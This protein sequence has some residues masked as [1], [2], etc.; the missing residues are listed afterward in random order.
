MISELALL[1]L[2]VKPL[3]LGQVGLADRYEILLE[4]FPH[5]SIR[6]IDRAVIRRAAQLRGRY[7]L[8][9]PDAIH[10]ATAVESGATLFV[11]NDKGLGPVKGIECVVLDDFV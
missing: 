2:L 1:E 8:R 11:C 3:N 10:L 5:L 4:N 7:R 6:P 9:T